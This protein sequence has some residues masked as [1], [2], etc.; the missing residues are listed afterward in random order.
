MISLPNS[1]N[2]QNPGG[3]VVPNFDKIE[4]RGRRHVSRRSIFGLVIAA[5]GAPAAA[6]ALPSVSSL[7][8]LDL[9]NAHTGERFKGPYRDE[10]GP[11]DT[12][13][14]ELSHFLRD[15]HCGQE[16]G[17]DLGVLDF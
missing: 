17:I 14:K 1:L 6:W 10:K 4:S 13:L 2:P 5:A 3:S 8:Q 15:F 12:A 7:R 11:I 9:I 16:I